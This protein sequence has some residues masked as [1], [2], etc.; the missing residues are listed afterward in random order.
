MLE[1]NRLN[2]KKNTDILVAFG[3]LGI[4]LMIIIPLPSAV[5]DVL[6]AF[7]ITLSAIIIMITMF[8]TNV[9]QLSVF[10]TLLLVTTLLRLGLNIS[11]TRLILSEG[12][13]G[14][15]IEAF[16]EFVIGGNYVVGIIIFLI[17]IIIQFVVITNGA[18]RVSEVSAR[19][20]LD[21]MPGKQMSID[22]DLNAG[23]IDE[24]TAR[25]RREDLQSEADFYGAMD[26]ASK[27]VKGDAIAGIIITIINIIAGIIIGVM[28]GMDFLQA[29]ATYTKLTIG[30]GL[31][32]QIP[33]LLISTASGIL[34]TR[35]G[36]AD[37]FGKTFSKQLTAFPVAL[38]IVSA[39]MFFLALIP[40]MPMFP[41]MLAAVTGAVSTYMLIKE[42]QK[43]QEEELA[44]VEEEY[45]ELERKEPENVMTLISVEPMEV[46]IGYGLI[47]LADESTGGDLL[48]RIASVRR[49]CA[50]EMGIVVQPIRIRDN[51]QLKTNEYVIKIRGTVIASAELMANMLL[52]MDPTGDNSQIAGIRTIEPTFKLPAVWINKDQRE[53]AEIKGLTVVDPTTVMVTHLTETI[54]SHS[55]ELLGR[56]EVQLIVENT[57]E[58]YSAVVDELIPDLM[59]IGELQKVLQNLLRE[60]VPIKDM[61]TIM[62]S[63]ADNSRLTKDLELLTEYV[64]FS[65]SRTICNQ[66]ID[67]ER[68]ITVVTLSPQIEEIIAANTQKSIQGSFPAVDPDTTT[69]IFNCIRDTIDRV[70]FYN[71]QPV[72]LVSPNIRPVF[73]KLI[74][75][76][77]PHIMVISLNEI[78][79]DV[80]IRTEGV[81]SL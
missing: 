68:A 15:I 7:N 37:N 57:K 18:G 34:V 80:E 58:K 73:R 60:K 12:S 49:Q 4:V 64:R 19:F 3:V 41:F 65:L 63:L 59:T 74:E 32:S 45:T 36:S 29:G 69:K 16:G 46:E 17:I 81:V 26:G 47:P 53:E 2:L 10:P 52:C 43:T 48:Q 28:G 9:L 78:P 35:S 14:K 67:E 30:D 77:F 38:G 50:I 44:R 70:Y 8:T 42:E 71:N 62:E 13:A 20:T 76:V 5:L 39:V 1:N 61:V 56:Q 11:S 21:A 27:F 51:L 55:Y 33:A 72:I 24:V 31:V 25:K 23:I 75:M 66:I 22:A 40:S 6:L 54:K 79:N